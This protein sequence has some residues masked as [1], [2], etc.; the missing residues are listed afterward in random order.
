[1]ANLCG[2]GTQ[3]AE[4]AI[5]ISDAWQNRG[6]GTRL[7]RLLIQIARDENVQNLFGKIMPRNLEMRRV[8]EKLG[9]QMTGDLA[10]CAIHAALNPHSI[11]AAA[12][13]D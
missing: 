5:V 6:L 2:P 8:P 10:D 9:F 7:L 4:F 13:R 12:G 3:D 1:L 11:P